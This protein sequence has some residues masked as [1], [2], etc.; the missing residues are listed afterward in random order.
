[1]LIPIAGKP[2]FPTP[3][4]AQDRQLLDALT[5]RHQRLETAVAELKADLLTLATR[6]EAPAAV[7]PPPLPEPPPIPPPAAE[8]PPLPFLPP[9]TPAAETPPPLPVTAPKTA[10]VPSAPEGPGL[11]IQ[12]G[13]W[14]ARI[15]VVFALL[16]LVYFSVVTYRDWL[17]YAGPWAKL[18]VLAAASAAL[19]GA[20]VRLERSLLV[21]GRTLAG[22]GLACLYYTLYGATYVEPLRV[23][24]SPLLGGL[25]LLAW[26]AGVLGIAQR[27]KSELLSIFAISLAYFSSA[28]TPVGGFTMAA[29]LILA[30]TAVV[31]LVRNAWTGLSYLC[32]IGTY[33]GFVRQIFAGVPD[34]PFSFD[35]V[36][37]LAFWPAA[38]YLTGAW[39]IFTAGIFLARGNFD[40]GK[41]LAFLSLNNGA[42]TGLLLVAAQLSHHGHLGG[43][44]I[45]VGAAQLVAWLL[46]QIFCTEI[47]EIYLLQGLAITTAGIVVATSGITRGLLL[48]AESLFLAG[49]GVTSRNAILRMG[50]GLTALLGSGY[51]ALEVATGHA[52]PWLL[53]FSGA[54]A[55]IACAWLE[56]RPYWSEP[57]GA[58][59]ARFI[60]TSAAYILLALGLLATGIFSRA[61]QAWIPPDLALSALVLSAM[62]YFL[63]LFEL[64]PLSQLLLILAQL[65]SFGL[66][67]IAFNPPWQDNVGYVYTPQWSQNIVAFVTMAFVLW[68]PRQTRLVKGAWLAPL[69]FLYALAMVAFTYNSVHPRVSEQTWLMSAAALSLLFVAFGAWN[70]SWAFVASGQ[71]LLALAVITFFHPDDATRF[72]WTWWAAAVPIAAVFLTGWIAH[73]VLAYAFDGD[74]VLRENLRVTGKL[75]QTLAI[76]MLIRWIF[77]IVPTNEITLILLALATAFIGGGL[78]ASS[79]YFVRAGLVLDL[80]GIGN[81]LIAGPDLDVHP[82]T[83]PDA[84][85]LALFVAQPA[86]LRHLGRDLISHTESWLV[87]GASSALAWLFATNSIAAAGSH[88]LTLGWALLALA[89]I[90]IGFAANER[91]QRWCGLGVL[92]A[93]FA[94]VA[95]HDFWGFSDVGKVVTFFAL[96]VICLGLSFL[97]YK[98]ADRL[99]EW[100]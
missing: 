12:F 73:R 38:I 41:R 18:S 97:Y 26:S 30:A 88:N 37:T 42:W 23:I 66:T 24:A 67:I 74:G 45:L 17:Q 65:A 80:F 86:L 54:A 63:P 69:M 44:L 59:R 52:H 76:A 25:L 70:R 60:P 19:I 31:F 81:Y 89:L 1:M 32:L 53:T 10:P 39:V 5:L 27:R 92:V 3:M 68:W 2:P 78:L 13:R 96:T 20:G 57:A 8:L 34:V 62:I 22:G 58:A 75:Y 46:A 85:A 21:Y 48:T 64:P 91:R 94:R 15:G 61:S 50:A 95:V 83:W 71:I 4:N 90:V 100:L 77:G 55:M 82:F 43:L 79:S 11:E 33:L 7:P 84:G 47:A 28:I 35:F 6:L 98:F 99:K 72:P 49:A 14:L 51:L 29:D 36:A 40:G 16:T 56:R 9:A 87:I 93:A